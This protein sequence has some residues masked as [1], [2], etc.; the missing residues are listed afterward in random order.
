MI[1]PVV[2]I[3]HVFP[4]AILIVLFFII[5]D[6]N[7]SKTDNLFNVVVLQANGLFILRAVYWFFI[8]MSADQV[9]IYEDKIGPVHILPFF[10]MLLYCGLLVY[11]QK[12]KGVALFKNILQ[13]SLFLFTFLFFANCVYRFLR[14]FVFILPMDLPAHTIIFLSIGLIAFVVPY[15]A[16]RKKLGKVDRFFIS[17]LTWFVYVLVFGL[18]KYILV[19]ILLSIDLIIFVAS[20]LALGKK[21]DKVRRFFI[22]ALIVFLFTS[23]KS[24]IVQCYIASQ[25]II[26]SRA[27]INVHNTGST[28]LT[29]ISMVVA[30][31]YCIVLIYVTRKSDDL[32]D[33]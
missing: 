23:V 28:T 14:V 13:R 3:R 15:L 27:S 8:A 7:S 18:S 12:K 10:L 21:F 30:S 33:A 29:V 11:V 17:A 31:L 9:M 5:K 4:L 6:K 22:S 26:H 32:V 19:N 20:Y 16:L 1:S 2:L 25:L 24:I